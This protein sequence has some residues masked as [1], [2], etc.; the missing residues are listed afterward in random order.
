[1]RRAQSSRP[2]T[3]TCP[4]CGQRLHAMSDHV[5]V[6]PEGDVE[7]RRHAHAECV[8][9]AHDRGTFRTYEEWR[10]TQPSRSLLDRLRRR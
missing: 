3:Y 7:R 1:M 2:A 5:V 10:R 9:A 6:A 4:F 8:A